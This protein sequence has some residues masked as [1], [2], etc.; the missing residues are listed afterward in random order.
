MFC[1][2]HDGVVKVYKV[3]FNRDRSDTKLLAKNETPVYLI[4]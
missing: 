3:H 4:L 2:F 1:I